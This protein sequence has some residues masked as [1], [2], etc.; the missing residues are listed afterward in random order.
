MKTM[1]EHDIALTF[2]VEEHEIMNEIMC[3]TLDSMFFSFGNITELHN[4]DPESYLSKRHKM[5]EGIM[6]KFHG[7]WNERFE[8]WN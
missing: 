8:D 7:K 2:T 3:H 4:M 1:K 6:Q 5:I